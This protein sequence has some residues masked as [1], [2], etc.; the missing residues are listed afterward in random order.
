MHTFDANHFE[1]TM[2]RTLLILSL[3]LSTP[4]FS[5]DWDT[6]LEFLLSD[7][8][9]SDQAREELSFLYESL[10][11]SPMNINTATPDELSQL[12]FLSDLQIENIQAYVYMHGPMQ[13]LGELQLT[14]GLDFSTRQLLKHFVYAG[15]VPQDEE[16]ID[17]SKV[18]S[19]GRQEVTG[20]LDIP[21]YR[22]D[23][24]INGKYA[25]GRLSHN[26]RWSFNWKNRIRFGLALD[27]D[28]GEAWGHDFHSPYL[29]CKDMGFVS[30]MAVGNFKASFGWGL[31]MN[32]GFSLGKSMTQSGSHGLKPHSST[33]ESGYFTGVGVTLGRGHVKYT[34]M[35]ALTPLDATLKGDSVIGS[36]KQDGLHRTELERSKKHNISLKTG[37]FNVRYHSRG[38]TLG[39]TALAEILPLPYKDRDVYAGV[40]ADWSLSRACFSI[41]G[42][43]SWSGGPATLNS[44]LLRL[45][46]GHEL[47]VVYRYYSPEYAALHASAFSERKVNDET[48]LMV[49]L[50]RSSRKLKANCYADFFR[51]IESGADGMDLKGQ[52]EWQPGKHDALILTARYKAKQKD[53]KYTG[54]LEYCLTTRCRLKWTHDFSDGSGLQTLLAYSRYDMVAEPISNGWAL[55][56]SYDR[57]FMGGRLDGSVS[58][59]VFLTDSYD[60]SVSVYEKGMRYSFNFMTMYGH[61]VRLSTV[62]KYSLGSHLNLSLK[63]G[64]TIYT[65][66]DEISSGQ[67]RIDSC[68]K[69]D[70]SLQFTWKY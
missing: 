65:D 64:S 3:F 67:Q 20:H 26:L 9:L 12:A 50:S 22:R 32:S 21:F 25:G 11:D 13:T 34:F 49:S 63:F 62:W 45:P 40:A 2:K 57:A 48:G 39:V 33:S 27:K 14:G 59:S 41:G 5:Q 53:C 51:Y 1:Y 16:R 42:E 56:S 55:A 19:D 29:Y 7:E 66:R 15:P 58:A 24:I 36:F 10:H 17:L 69:E 46:A 68:H 43:T 47:N 37:V 38:V 61:G 31:L 54:A 6:T 30:V 23:G 60:S 8:D 28:A 70:L 4:L 35:S 44:L 52:L 18:I